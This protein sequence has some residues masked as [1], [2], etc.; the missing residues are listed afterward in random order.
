MNRTLA[1]AAAIAAL[2]IGASVAQATDAG[3]LAAAKKEGTVVV[4][5]SWPKAGM[6]AMADAFTKN[7][8]VKVEFTNIA[9]S[10]VIQRFLAEREAN[11]AVVDVVNISAL[12]P[13]VDFKK[14]NLLLQYH[15]PEIKAYPQAYQDSD[16]YWMNLGHSAEVIVYNTDR[17]PPNKAPKNW[18]DLADAAFA[19]VL[20]VPDIKG[21]G[22]GY[23]W[24][25]AMRDVLGVSFHEKIGALKPQLFVS[26]AA[27]GQ[28]VMSG[29]AFVAAGILHY[30]GTN[31]LKADPKAP[32]RVV[33]PD[34]L[35]LTDL[36]VAIS[37]TAP[38]AN[39]AK[40]FV[41]FVASEA[42]QALG[43]AQQ[44]MISPRPGVA[45]QNVP[46][47]SKFKKYSIAAH[48]LE[49]YFKVEAEYN[50]EFARLYSK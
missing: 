35:P 50:A 27:M 26:T 41:D 24:Y 36:V 15:S 17:V 37:N 3:I 40:A 6:V 10:E 20:A 5:G 11:R 32:I 23:L 46:D 45:T 9:S 25:Y 1:S 16:G 13:F 4:Y 19:K 2:T 21:G 14:R 34:P 33:W 39:A 47:L 18:Q 42:G 49:A 31:A 8:G 28:A 38:H 12:A 30:T 48:Q 7:T 22:T 44:G 43:V 29:E